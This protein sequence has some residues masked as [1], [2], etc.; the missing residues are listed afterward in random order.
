[1]PFKRIGTR[2]RRPSRWLGYNLVFD[3]QFKYKPF[4]CGRAAGLY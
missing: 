3:E 4:L 2:I 1:M